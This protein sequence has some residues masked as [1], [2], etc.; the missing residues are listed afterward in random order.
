M[1][2]REESVT[3]DGHFKFA[4]IEFLENGLCEALIIVQDGDFDWTCHCAFTTLYLLSEKNL[5]RLK[6]EKREK[7][8]L[9]E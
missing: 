2:I 6:I 7:E 8:R 3:E 1:V 4:G 5:G 9:C